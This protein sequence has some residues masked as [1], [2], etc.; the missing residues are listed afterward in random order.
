[1]SE[2][3]RAIDSHPKYSIT[4]DGRVINS[5]GNEKALK[6]L[7]NG[8]A[9]V[10]LY[11][12]GTR[13]IKRVHRL[14][15]EAFIPNPDNK[16]D[17]NHKDGNKLN[18]SVSN[19]E[20]VT[21]SE[22]MRHA[23]DTGLVKPHATYGMRGHKNPN[24]GRKGRKVKIIETGEIFNSVKDCAES[25]HGNDRCICDCMNGK[26]GSHRGYHFESI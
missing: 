26:Q 4:S 17:I 3:R 19:L 9:S 10:D 15:A 13:T 5:R 24:G 23:Y 2:V 18:N 1:M 12:N 11:D 6:S 14:V 16:P 22:N 20:W 7:R 25:I 21:K 8:Y